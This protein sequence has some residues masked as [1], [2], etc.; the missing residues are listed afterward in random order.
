MPKRLAEIVVDTALAGRDDVMRAARLADRD[1]VP[2]VVALV[3]QIGIDEIALVTAIKRQVRVALSDP[4]TVEHDLDAIRELPRDTCERLRTMPLTLSYP[5]ADS[6]VLHVA[7]ADPTD[8]VAIAEIEHVTGCR[9]KPSLMPLSSIE[10]LVEKA[11]KAFVTEVIPRKNRAPYGE[12]LEATTQPIPRPEP[13][14]VSEPEVD[15]EQ[16]AKGPAPAKK[17]STLPFHR[18]ADEASVELRVQALLELLI[19]KGVL[20]SDEY[21]EHVRALMKQRDDDA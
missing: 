14:V 6:K 2:L 18:V 12:A 11:Y 4:A 21:H 15:E 16:T 5:S 17:P 7:M 3:R 20:T 8:T 1:Q 10:E 13:P 19:D 9:V